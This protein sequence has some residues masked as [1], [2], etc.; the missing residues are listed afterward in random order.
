MAATIL[1][2]DDEKNIR[3]SLGRMFELEGYPCVSAGSVS[4]SLRV[5]SEQTPDLAL[6]DVHLPDGNGLELLQLLKK[7]H[8]RLPVVMMSGQG[9]ID[10]AL[11]AIRHGAQD[12]LEKPLSTDRVLITVANALRFERTHRELVTLRNKITP[13]ATLLG[14]SRAMNALQET[15][16]LAAPTKSRV[17]VTG[18]SGTGKELV[19]RQVHEL[20]RRSQG[21]FIKV[22]CAAIPKDL[23]ESELF[24]HERGAFTGAT[25]SRQGKFELA[26]GGTL[27]L[28]EVG[29]MRLDVQAKLLRALQEGEIERVGGSRTI[30]VDVRV[31]AAT[32]K[33]LETAISEGH[34]REDLFYRLNVIPIKLP[35]LRD[36][37]E[38]LPTLTDAFVLQICNENELPPKHLTPAATD[39]MTR[40]DWPG[41]V[42]EL[43]N[44][45]ERLV[46]LTPGDQIDAPDVDRLLG[47]SQRNG[48]QFYR[49]DTPMKS[50]VAEAE[51]AIIQA[52]LDANQGHVTRTAAS[53][54]L[55][56]SH[57]YKKM[58]ALGIER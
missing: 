53:L 43:R 56:R 22:N 14:N 6:L 50:L 33:D 5:L 15:L 11:Q 19:A 29:D 2:V 16:R 10:L 52:A 42:R 9:T 36:R 49:P 23:I 44:A 54:A 31:V 41:N 24:G 51:R 1:I 8:P 20:S 17:L 58:R 37:K 45:C 32:N 13:G 30:Q 57:L 40:H 38:D 7:K 27:F 4:E 25:G 47:N 39:A 34:F 55:E 21:P 26:D 18:E 46:I 28:D 35:P 48:A 12:F 3:L